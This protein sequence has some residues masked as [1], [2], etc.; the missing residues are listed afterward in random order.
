MKNFKQ[1]IILITSMVIS[2]FTQST[3]A[4][5]DTF[6]K[7]YLERLENSRKYMLL[8]AESMPEDKYSFKTTPESMSF[9]EH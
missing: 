2:S 3:F 5:E 4:Q 8:V 7:E 1:V 9:A 6:I